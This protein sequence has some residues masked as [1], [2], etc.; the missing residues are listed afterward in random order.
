MIPESHPLIETLTEE[1]ADNAE[2]RMGAQ[3]FLEESF[4]ADHPG[5]EDV[6]ARL[7]SGGRGWFSRWRMILLWVLAALALG[8]AI[9][10]HAPT[11]R[12]VGLVYNRNIF[13]RWDKVE[14]PA[15]LTEE[16]RL[17][18]GDPEMD[19]VEGKRQ[20]HDYAP[21]NPAYFAEY[22]Q[23]FVSR[24]EVLPPDFLETA[25][26]IAPD[27]AF[28]P[29][30]AAGRIGK[31]SIHK[32][33]SS[34]PSRPSRYV[35][36]VRLAPVAREIESEIIDADALEEALQLIDKATALVGF[37]TYVNPMAA[38]R[39][40]LFP[41]DTMVSFVGALMQVYS[42]TS[43]MIQLRN[44]ADLLSA[45]A[46]QL[47]KSGRAEEFL[48][49]ARQRDAFISH[50]GRNPDSNLVGELVY[51]VIASS[52]ATNFHFAAERLGLGELAEGYLE[53]SE[54]FQE[55]RDQRDIR[56]KTEDEP[57]LVEQAS[58]L[59][60]MTLPMISRQVLS[61]VPVSASDYEPMR[62]A[63]HE[64]MGG[65]GVLALALLISPGAVVV[66]YF[67]RATSPMIRLPAKRMAGVLGLVDW[68]WVTA[69]GIGMPIVFFLIVTR[70]TSLGGREY[71]APHF[72]LMFPGV[73][74]V[75]LLLGLWIGPAIVVRWRLGRRLALFGFGDRFTVPVFVA[76]LV[77][78]GVW[79][80]VA[81]PLVVRFGM[82]RYSL[83]ALAGPAVLCL[84]I[85][86]A[87][88]LRSIMGKPAAR[89]AQCT[90]AIAVLPAYPLAIIALCALTPI[91]PAAEKRWLA[92]ETLI[93]FNPEEPDFGA[94]EYRVAA[95]KRKE[96]N[97][98]TGVE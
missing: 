93:R 40:R 52:T 8:S 14:P 71:G 74:Y 54:A 57:F 29:Y 13:E 45:R 38:A 7:E 3:V 80:L 43:G 10:S 11:F 36:G 6:A 49:L 90:T 77:T 55:D 31:E 22:A 16:Q 26:R 47:S 34:S 56:G 89:L 42:G 73:Q 75:A 33:R 79:T 94:Y 1:L 61:Q 51:A 5:V 60:H 4:D 2:R 25:A 62:R 91:Y 30:F 19:D 18:L 39:M 96:I 64:L 15:G 46:E 68:L 83:T 86:F 69:L 97:A 32:Q 37:E 88:A 92:K 98:I 58:T 78:V 50:L 66:F 67:R 84:C 63:E 48:V 27:N 41:A 44:V 65:L 9:F 81:L 12:F 82:N 53:Q 85:V 28:F 95:Q 24:M 17:L 23:V 70:L 76:V 72:L 20:L 21:E 87:N 35:D 59:T